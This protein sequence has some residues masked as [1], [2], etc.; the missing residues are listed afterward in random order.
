VCRKTRTIFLGDIPFGDSTDGLSE[1]KENMP[2]R[3]LLGIHLLRNSGTRPITVMI[4]SDGGGLGHAFAIYD[5]L[6]ECP[7]E[8]R[9]RVYGSALS[10]AALILQA[11]DVRQI[12][13]HARVMLHYGSEEVQ[14]DTPHVVRNRIGQESVRVARLMED[15]FLERMRR[16][17]PACTRAHVK[18]I[19]EVDTYYSAEEAV[20]M[21]LADEIIKLYSF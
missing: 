15:V 8:I 17:N 7:C 6:R 9:V 2:E 13:P 14:T 11:G 3:F 19:L 12:A 21:G 1:R 4:N 16:V 10:S 18:K 20:E 5:M